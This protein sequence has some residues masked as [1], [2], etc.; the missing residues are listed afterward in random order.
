MKIE[1]KYKN[2]VIKINGHVGDHIT[3]TINSSKKFYEQNLLEYI[4]S[5][6]TGGNALDIGAN[7]GNH[8]VYFSKFIF[9]K[10]FA[11]EAN[12]NNFQLLS[13]NKKDNNINDKLYIYHTAL[14]DGKYK[15]K[16]DNIVAN[17]GANR[18]IEGEGDLTTTKIDDYPL[19]K[20]DFIKIDVERHELKVLKG[21]DNLIKR[22]FP[23]IVLECTANTASDF[24]IIAPYLKDLGYEPIHSF[25]NT[26]Y[27]FV[28]HY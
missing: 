9:D 27:Y 23:E 7:I 8:S 14:S 26:L 1:F 12:E 20:I 22:D 25:S 5:R 28:K 19:P 21:A 4:E 10:T 6:F 16:S 2:D 11:F 24:K 3:N 18:V 13:K 15:F 17:M